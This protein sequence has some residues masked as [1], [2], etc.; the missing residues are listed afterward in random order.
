MA[1]S[2]FITAT[3]AE[4]ATPSMRR[5]SSSA[6]SSSSSSSSFLVASASSSSIGDGSVAQYAAQ[7][8]LH[9]QPSAPASPL[10][11]SSAMPRSAIKSASHSSSSSS[12]QR[13]NPERKRRQVKFSTVEVR[14][15]PMTLGVGPVSSGAPVGLDWNPIRSYT[16]T[17]ASIEI[18][19]LEREMESMMMSS[20]CSLS[21]DDSMLS[22]YTASPYLMPLTSQQRYSILYK[23]GVPNDAILH[24]VMDS[25]CCQQQRLET[26]MTLKLERA[27]RYMKRLQR[28]VASSVVFPKPIVTGAQYHHGH[29]AQ[30]YPSAANIMPMQQSTGVVMLSATSA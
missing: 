24:S 28:Q 18:Q 9:H 5:R 27:A 6:S 12:S 10:S 1:Q 25:K 2:S 13:K 21:S 11:A 17:V 4:T 7:G 15:Y 16:A 30:Q 26:Q 8:P 29:H 23:A 3:A 22:S 14:E 19:K 20:S